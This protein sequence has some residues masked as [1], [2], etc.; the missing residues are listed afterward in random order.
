MMMP[1]DANRR[2]QS[3]DPA[4]DPEASASPP[5]VWLLLGNR[6]GD[7]N[8]LMA[9]A[10]GLG[11]PYEAKA[12]DYNA[13][14]RIP[15]LR[16]PS[17]LL[18]T[19]KS[20]ALIKPPWPDLVIGVGYGSVPVAR[21]IRRQ[22][23]GTRLVIVGNP[24]SSIDDLDLLITT[25][26][27]SQPPAPNVVALPMP[28]GN[29]AKAVTPT[30]D[31]ARWLRSHPGPLR[32]IAVGGPARY[33]KIDQSELRRAIAAVRKRCDSEGGTAIAA[34]SPRTDKS[35]R[36]TVAEALAGSRF[37][38][39]DN[40]PR[41]AVLLARSD[42]FYVTAD[43]VSMISEAMLTGKPVATIPIA[44]SVRGQVCAWL[45]RLRLIEPP[46]PDFETFW[47]YLATHEMVG[48]VDKPV[49]TKVSNTLATATRAVL[50][51]LAERQAR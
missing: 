13:L 7:N 40:F 51:L 19:R 48:P 29:P 33:W 11:F 36:R 18:L 4:E 46:Y 34:F 15:F 32:L 9:L 1:D 3:S 50:A 35:T 2:F 8:Q 16:Q 21:Y 45:T 26:Q 27:Y 17:L 14:R 39:L 49:A 25:P 23:P 30:G 28:I 22:S 41:F 42:E 20:R 44:R 12:L 24:R 10:E 31:E 5:T 38:L 47:S 43:S 37:P 6:R